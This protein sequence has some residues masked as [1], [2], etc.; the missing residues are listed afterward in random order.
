MALRSRS[1]SLSDTSS[2]EYEEALPGLKTPAPA[3]PDLDAHI[4]EVTV[5][6][7]LLF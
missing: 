6:V 3:S 7:R 1:L 5:H 2:V 4:V